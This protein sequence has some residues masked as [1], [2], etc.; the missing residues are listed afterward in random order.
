MARAPR[1]RSAAESL[2]EPLVYRRG[3]PAGTVTDEVGIGTDPGPGVQRRDGCHR[4]EP[5]QRCD[6]LASQGSSPIHASARTDC[7]TLR[8]ITS[9]TLA[10]RRCNHGLT[11]NNKISVY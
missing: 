7:L 11:P 8:P 2:A 1:R 9:P 10:L 5:D 4:D 6:T 3:E